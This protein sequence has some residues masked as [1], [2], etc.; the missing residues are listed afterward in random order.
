MRLKG[1][2]QDC[3]NIQPLES[4]KLKTIRRIDQLHLSEA[5]KYFK[6]ESAREGLV[7]I[8]YENKYGQ[9]SRIYQAIKLLLFSPSSALYSCPLAMADGAA[10]VLAERKDCKYSAALLAKLLSRTEAWTSG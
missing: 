1:I 5:W 9:Y 2:L 6:G 3:S 7:A 4:K 10:A 8:P